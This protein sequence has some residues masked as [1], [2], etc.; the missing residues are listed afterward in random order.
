MIDRRWLARALLLRL[1]PHLKGV[2][3]RRTTASTLDEYGTPIRQLHDVAGLALIVRGDAA[4][5]VR[6]IGQRALV[7]DIGEILLAQVLRSL[8]QQQRRGI[9]KVIKLCGKITKSLLLTCSFP[10]DRLLVWREPMNVSHAASHHTGV[11][12]IPL[13]LC[14]GH[15]H[16]VHIAS[17][18]VCS[19]CEPELLLAKRVLGKIILLLLIV[20][21]SIVDRAKVD[22]ASW[23]VTRQLE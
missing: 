4:L 15:L 1:L 3:A 14:L 17:A 22:R 6:L 12:A 16:P 10:C 21:Q 8:P 7:G 20:P 23:I 2:H 18:L 13:R 19:L 9:A 5:L 11:L